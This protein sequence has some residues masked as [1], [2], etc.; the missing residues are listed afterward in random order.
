MVGIWFVVLV[1]LE[2]RCP[3]MASKFKKQSSPIYL[4]TSVGHGYDPGFLAVNPQVT[5]VSPVIG[6]RYFPPDPRLLY[7]PKRSP[8][9]GYQITCTCILLGNR[10]TPV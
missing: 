4:I 6:C 3:T 10:G 9:L 5:L 8:P 2:V 7:Q 1:K